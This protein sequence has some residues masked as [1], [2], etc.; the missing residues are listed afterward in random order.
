M[1]IDLLGMRLQCHARPRGC[2]INRQSSA[3]ASQ[4]DEDIYAMINAGEDTVC[5]GIFEGAAGAWWRVVDTS[6]AS[7]DDIAEPGDEVA[8]NSSRYDVAPRSVVVLVRPEKG[9]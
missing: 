7:P 8:V 6:L 2:A 4:Y 3:G 9:A 5:F 1:R